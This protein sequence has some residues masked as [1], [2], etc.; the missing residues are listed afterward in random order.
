MRDW[1]AESGGEGW[2]YGVDALDLIYVGGVERGG[3]G[4]EGQK[5]RVGRRDG[6]CMKTGKGISA[7]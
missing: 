7:Y 1:G 2:G 6:V 3:K 5:G 4:S